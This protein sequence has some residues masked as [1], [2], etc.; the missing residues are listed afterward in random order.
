[1]SND[2]IRIKMTIG[3][4]TVVAKLQDNASSRNL[5]ARFPLTLTLADYANTEKIV[6]LPE[7]LSTQGAPAGF[8]ASRGD[9]TY[10]APW[11]NL[12]IFYKDFR[13]ADGLVRLGVI[14]TG[15]EDLT[16]LDGPVDITLAVLPA[17][18]EPAASHHTA[19]SLIIDDT[20]I[21]GV[22]NDSRSSRELISRLPYTVK[23]QRYAHDY[24]GVMDE[25]LPYDR[26]D[27]HNGWHNGDIAFAADGDYFTI[28]Y[29]DEEISQQFGNLVT[30][31]RVEGSLAI[32]DSLNPE[33]SVRMEIDAATPASGP[34][35]STP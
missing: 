7:K 24:C 30:L 15:L 1:M 32:M 18:S 16:A 11:G 25:P 2:A 35:R 6:Q 34:E 9:V 27:L 29:R 19:V 28:L 8:A 23:L 3:D 10:Y 31:G 33:I 21:P 13:Y 20:V 14:E 17:A 4:K 22:L 26:S 5:V 12:A